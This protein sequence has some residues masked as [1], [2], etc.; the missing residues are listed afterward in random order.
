MHVFRDTPV[1]HVLTQPSCSF[2]SPTN[3]PVCDTLFFKTCTHCT[4]PD[5]VK[6]FNSTTNQQPCL[7]G[8]GLPVST[9]WAY[10]SAPDGLT[11]QHRMGLPVSTGWAYRSAPDGLT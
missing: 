7:T 9:G 8:K 5:S 11:G 3:N 4:R 1:S 10:R 2:Q 6:L